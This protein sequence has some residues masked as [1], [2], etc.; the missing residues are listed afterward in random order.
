MSDISEEGLV[1]YKETLA[2]VVGFKEA[3]SPG[4]LVV[5]DTEGS[6]L[7]V[8]DELMPLSRLRSAMVE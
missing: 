6:P 2:K 5:D 7:F 4:L 1:V 8:L 3:T